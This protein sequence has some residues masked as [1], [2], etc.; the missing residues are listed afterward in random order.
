V[1]KGLSNFGA[2]CKASVSPAMTTISTWASEIVG[3][4]VSPGALQVIAPQ[5]V[6]SQLSKIPATT[7]AS[8]AGYGG[9]KV[10]SRAA[11][12]VMTNP[13]IGEGQ[14]ISTRQYPL[15]SATLTP[16][17]V[18][19]LTELTLETFKYSITDVE[20]L[21]SAAMADET[22][23]KIDFVLLGNTAATS[24]SPAGLLNSVSATPPTAGGS[25]PAF[26]GDVRALAAAIETTGPL[27]MP[28]LIM[29]V[30]SAMLLGS[31]LMGWLSEGG[32]TDLPFITSPTVPQKMV[33]M[34]D[35]AHFASGEGDTPLIDASK[36]VTLHEE[37]TAPLALASGATGAAVVAAPQRSMFQTGCIAIRLLQDVTWCMT[38]PGRVSFIN[39][40]SW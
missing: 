6:Y 25:L 29:S 28:T 22:A 36:E 35:A 26:A 10:P 9:V 37:D 12:T 14:P 4:G 23:A 39:S 7:R 18:G 11:P 15:T 33:I 38:R 21:I 19:V 8:L 5:S 32:P 34:V 40:V 3:V 17:K 30:T 16:K 1:L 20:R 13:F 24:I 2:V 27:I 31:Q